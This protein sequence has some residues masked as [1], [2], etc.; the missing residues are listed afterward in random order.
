MLG[1]GGGIDGSWTDPVATGGVANSSNG[2]G[3]GST[4]L[5]EESG[6]PWFG[7]VEGEATHPDTDIDVFGYANMTHIPGASLEANEDFDFDIGKYADWA[8]YL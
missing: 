5:V 7:V 2:D 3:L 6:G 4:L 1:S 8:Y